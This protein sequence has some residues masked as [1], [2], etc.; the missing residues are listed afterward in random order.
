MCGDM[1]G[2]HVVPLLQFGMGLCGTLNYG[3]FVSKYENLLAYGDTK[4]S[5][6]GQ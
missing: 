4:V 2:E 3:L 6:P 1:C 5:S